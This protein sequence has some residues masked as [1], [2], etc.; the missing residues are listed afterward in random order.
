MDN[1]DN[2]ERPNDFLFHGHDS[3]VCPIL[4]I[5]EELVLESDEFLR[6]TEEFKERTEFTE[7]LTQM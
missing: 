6:K 4:D 2:F 5:V 1:Y 3:D 7:V